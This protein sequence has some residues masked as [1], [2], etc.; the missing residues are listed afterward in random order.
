M[1]GGGIGLGYVASIVAVNQYFERRRPLTYGITLLGHA[2]SQRRRPEGHPQPRSEAA[3]GALQL[4]RRRR[5]PRLRV[6]DL[7]HQLVVLTY[8]LHARSRLALG[9]ASAPARL[10]P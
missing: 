1:V 5:A 10:Q 6:L 7:H 2:A 9:H 3:R 8:Q 4:D